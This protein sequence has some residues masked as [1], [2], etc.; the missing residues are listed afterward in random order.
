MGASIVKWTAPNPCP[1]LNEN[2]SKLYTNFEFCA[3]KNHTHDSKHIDSQSQ[4]IH[5][6]KNNSKKSLHILEDG[7]SR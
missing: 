2:N 1:M 4:V 3:R 7:A 6:D 5:D